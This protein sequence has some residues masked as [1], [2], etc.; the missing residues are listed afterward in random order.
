MA[1]DIGGGTSVTGRM[2]LGTEANDGAVYE[3]FWDEFIPRVPHKQ[4]H[5][6]M[7]LDLLLR[8]EQVEAACG[9]AGAD[10][11]KTCDEKVDKD[12]Q[13]GLCNDCCESNRGT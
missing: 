5:R 3:S 10:I 7:D 4:T 13:G 11:Y 9:D 12:C 1:G 8:A 6:N 2:D